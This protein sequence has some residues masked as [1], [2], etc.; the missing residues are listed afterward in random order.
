MNAP[1]EGSPLSPPRRLI[2]GSVPATPEDLFARM[3][4]LGLQVSTVHHPPV[5][6]V[7][8]ARALRGPLQGSH[9]KNLFL[10]NKKGRMWLVVCLENRGVDLRALGRALG[11]G[12]LSFGSPRRLMEN[13][14]V[15]PGAVTPLG[16]INDRGGRVRVVLDSALLLE[17]PVNFHPLDNGMT[18]SLSVDDFLRF[19]RA[20]DHEP[21]VLDMEELES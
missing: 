4:R 16:V 21:Q 19:L 6:T 9:A 11:A 17:G 13:L 14:G 2:D 20:E 3:S 18:S 8:E 15:V 7:E 5:F 12:H 10:R 1:D